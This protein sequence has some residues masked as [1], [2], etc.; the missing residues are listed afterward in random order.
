MTV[1]PFKLRV[2]SDRSANSS[3]DRSTR[4]AA[5][6]SPSSLTRMPARPAAYRTSRRTPAADSTAMISITLV[7]TPAWSAAQISS[8]DISTASAERVG[9][10]HL[11]PGSGTPPPAVPATASGTANNPGAAR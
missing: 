4:S 3:S 6:P 9:T 11:A 10:A 7:H 8:R 5:T 1:W 2:S